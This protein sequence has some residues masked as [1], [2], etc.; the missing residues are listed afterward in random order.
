M[1][2][3][4]IEGM[5]NVRDEAKREFRNEVKL[6]IGRVVWDEVADEIWLKIWDDVGCEVKLELI[7]EN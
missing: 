2:T 6:D 1:S 5:Y 7:D 3:L 4:T